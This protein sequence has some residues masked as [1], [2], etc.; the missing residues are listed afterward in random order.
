MVGE[1]TMVEEMIMAVPGMVGVRSSISAMV[2]FEAQ[3]ASSS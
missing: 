3:C 1:M 2:V